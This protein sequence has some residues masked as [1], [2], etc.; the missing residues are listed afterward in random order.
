MMGYKGIVRNGVVVLENG[1]TLPEGTPVM[2]EFKAISA[3]ESNTMVDVNGDGA[4]LSDSI[5]KFAGCL[6]DKPSDFAR[7]HDHYIHGTRKK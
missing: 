5:L 2:V 7:N 4:P 6:K 1:L 3:K